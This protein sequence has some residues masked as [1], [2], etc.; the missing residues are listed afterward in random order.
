M[1][2][3]SR[4]VSCWRSRLRAY[5][6]NVSPQPE[7]TMLGWGGGM[8][9]VILLQTQY[10]SFMSVGLDAFARNCGIVQRPFRGSPIP[11]HTMIHSPCFAHT[12]VAVCHQQLKAGNCL[13]A[14]AVRCIWIKKY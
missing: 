4:W 13:I 6:A 9:R 11:T 2:L 8:M 1:V 12:P 3:M 7:D 5:R 14:D 10:G